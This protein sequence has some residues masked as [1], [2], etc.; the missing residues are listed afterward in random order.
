MVAMSVAMSV[1]RLVA[2]KVGSLAER[3]AVKLDEL[4]VAMLVGVLVGL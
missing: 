2:G 4:K 1:G 3:W